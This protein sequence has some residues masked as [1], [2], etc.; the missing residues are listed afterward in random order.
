MRDLPNASLMLAFI[1]RRFAFATTACFIVGLVPTAR[2]LA[3]G[4][5]LARVRERGNVRCAS[6]VR[7]GIA[8]P[9]SD[10]ARW[11]G[12]APDICRAVAAAVLG[13]AAKIAFRP[14]F[15]GAGQS[16]HP[17]EPDDIVFLG[18]EQAVTQLADART[19]LQLGPAVVHDALGILVHAAGA[20]DVAGLAARSICVEPGTA[21]DRALTRYFDARS[22]SLHEHP[23]QE[24]DEMR[25]AFETGNCDALA[26]PLSTLAS[27]R[28]DPS[29]GHAADRILDDVLADDPIFAAT[30]SDARWSRIVWWTFSA[31]VDAE[32]AGL[33]AKTVTKE[34]VVPGV[35][36]AVGTSLGLAPGW[37]SDA[38]VA[39]G[40]Y[41]EIFDRDLGATSNFRLRRGANALWRNGGLIDALHAE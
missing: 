4:D 1:S 37:T 11:Y 41:G 20:A 32:D 12:I 26:G 27:V 21:A 19:P 31:L 30:P 9:T 23:Y 16:A 28:A 25:Q 29:E 24:P 8:V 14:Y 17:E 36:P 34:T 13:I 15:D 18:A 2:A 40:N 35:P 38:I 5:V 7:P 10:G 39:S 6:V 3:D 22:L 33:S